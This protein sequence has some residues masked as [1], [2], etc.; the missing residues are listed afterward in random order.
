MRSRHCSAK[1]VPWKAS[2]SDAAAMMRSRVY[3]DTATQWSCA[4]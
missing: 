2:I 4:R 1:R 3:S